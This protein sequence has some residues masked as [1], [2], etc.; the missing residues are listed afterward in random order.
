MPAVSVII[1][2]YN[3]ARFLRQRIDTVLNQTFQ[4]FEVIILDDC[5]TDNSRQIIESYRG[6]EKISHIIYNEKNSGSPFKQWQKGIELAA[7]E[8]VWIA[9]SDDYAEPEFLMEVYGLVK[10][11]GNIGIAFCGSRWVDEKGNEGRDGDLY[12]NDFVREGKEEIKT[13]AKYNTIQNASA[14]II[15]TALAKKYM[16]HSISLKSCGDWMLYVNIL[17]ESNVAFSSRKLN[18]FRWYHDSV[19]S[20]AKKQGL[21]LREGLFILNKSNAYLGSFSL[22]SIRILYRF[23][24][25]KIKGADLK[26][27]FYSA[28]VM[29]SLKYVLS[30][31]G[32]K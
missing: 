4:D 28:F 32:L 20:Q 17:T 1:P 19:S 23:W 18:Y 31:I 30:K 29:F 14:A 16:L 13:L 26:P 12:Q 6:N 7:G 3:H 2:N 8:Y 5:S 15:K 25:N 27:K 10:G 24:K 21:W 9:E 22:G 11:N